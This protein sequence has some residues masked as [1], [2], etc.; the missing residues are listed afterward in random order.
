MGDRTPP[1]ST[2]RVDAIDGKS[3]THFSP[4]EFW[5]DPHT[6]RH[7]TVGEYG[8]SMSHLRIWDMIISENIPIAIILEEDAKCLTNLG[9]FVDNCPV[10]FDFLYLGRKKIG[11]L[12]EDELSPGF[13]K[14]KYSYWTVGYAITQKGARILAAGSL[15]DS[16]VPVDEYISLMSDTNPHR[17]ILPECT[18]SLLAVAPRDLVVRPLNEEASTTFFS[19][20][21]PVYFRQV[22]LVCVATHMN[23]GA[24]RFHET[25]RQYG[26]DVV[27]LGLNT[28]WTG[29]EM[30][31]GTGGGIKLKLLR[32][33]LASKSHDD[34]VIFSDAFDVV[35]N[36]HA[37]DTVQKYY[38]HYEG[39]IVF[40]GEA[41]CWPDR[42]RASHFDGPHPHKYLN[43]GGIIGK[44]G[45][46]LHALDPIPIVDTDDDQRICTDIF[47]SLRESCIIDKQCRIFLCL[48]NSYPNKVEGYRLD[49]SRS[50]LYFRG[51]RPAFVHGNG[52]AK[53]D[54]NT[55]CN[56]LYENSATYGTK[57]KLQEGNHSVTLVVIQGSSKIRREFTRSVVRVAEKCSKVVFVG[58][59]NIHIELSIPVEIAA[60]VEDVYVE[61]PYV[62]IMTTDV[63]LQSSVIANCMAHASRDSIVAPLLRKPRGSLFSNFWGAID[64]KGYYR[65]SEEYTKILERELVG[66]FAVPYVWYAFLTPREL[67]TP[68]TLGLRGR[69][70]GDRDMSYCEWMR[71]NDYFMYVVNFFSDGYLF[72]AETNVEKIEKTLDHYPIQEL[73]REGDELFS[74]TI[75]SKHV[76]DQIIEKANI[77]GWS[78]GGFPYHDARLGAIEN[79]PTQDVHLKD[80]G[81]QGPFKE[82]LFNVIAPLVNKEFSYQTKDINIAFVV[83]YSMGGQRELKEHHDSSA[84]SV[85]VCLNDDFEGGGVYFPR[86]KRFFPHKEVGKMLLHP[87]RMTHLHCGRPITRGVRFVLV[88]FIN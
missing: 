30:S 13:V 50:A 19:P 71:R 54:L 23:A 8:C 82:L 67:F 75:F 22:T 68:E 17:D 57:S 55:A 61:T 58:H 1:Q 59:P 60:N 45:D 39:S 84:Y 87:G 42:D 6:H 53:I 35:V 76:C 11:D 5:R 31:K 7:L 38:E 62:F 47:L 70:N 25:A 21:V 26:Y 72:D 44:A 52:A 48:A 85:T 88:A 20:P 51:E 24:R 49:K 78:Q 79:H 36:D 83:R 41:T 34:L 56:W 28:A 18:A 63:S 29:G 3:L 80:I 2:D 14:A 32:S 37:S 33:F 16:V 27:T 12:P 40:A 43:S 64:G 46:I 4:Y 81:L 77:A 74:A 73:T 15:R 66:R 10:D 69:N 9:T 86:Q 65:R